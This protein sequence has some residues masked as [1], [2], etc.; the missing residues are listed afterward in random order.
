MLIPRW[1]SVL[2]SRNSLIWAFSAPKLIPEAVISSHAA[3]F[4]STPFA[5]QK[6]KS[7]WKSDVKATQQPPSKDHIRFTTSQKNS[8]RKKAFNSFL[9][10]G[11][12]SNTSSKAEDPIKNG[13]FKDWNADGTDKKQRPKVFIK[14]AGNGKSHYKKMKRRNKRSF[15]DEDTYSDPATVFRATFGEKQYTWSFAGDHFSGDSASGFERT[16]ESEWTNRRNRGWAISSDSE[17][18][19]DEEDYSNALRETHSDRTILGLPPSGPLKIEDVKNAFRLS[20]LKWHPDKHQG[21]SQEM[22]EEKFKLCV[23]AYKS[24]CAALS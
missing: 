7:K 13:R 8:D 5:C 18:E 24:L 11:G 15:S 2:V 20:A 3:S 10:H 22:A 16:T 6:W 17:S 23:T 19:C 9:F 21:P 14:H 4:H 1:R 12:I